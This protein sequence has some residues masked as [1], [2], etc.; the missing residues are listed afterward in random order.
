MSGSDEDDVGRQVLLVEPADLLQIDLGTVIVE[1]E[2]PAVLAADA[3]REAPARHR[4]VADL[5]LAGERDEAH[6]VGPLA[7]RHLE[8]LDGLPDEEDEQGLVP[9]G[10]GRHLLVAANG[11]TLN[12]T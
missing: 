6:A 11:Q 1:G 2:E 7:G 9:P 4:L 8:D 12:L 10:G 5:G 3:D